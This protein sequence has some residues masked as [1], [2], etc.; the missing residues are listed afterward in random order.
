MV[1]KAYLS[2]LMNQEISEKAARLGSI[3][4]EAR[5]LRS[6]KDFSALSQE[7]VE[8]FLLCGRTQCDEITKLSAPQSE[9]AHSWKQLAHLGLVPGVCRFKRQSGSSAGML[10]RFEGVASGPRVFG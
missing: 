4:A 5:A 3:A 1:R 7:E 6:P 9:A 8:F 10:G 2:V